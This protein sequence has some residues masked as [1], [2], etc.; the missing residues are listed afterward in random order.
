MTTR[1]HRTY[2]KLRQCLEVFNKGEE[3][4][5]ATE[6]AIMAGLIATVIEGAVTTFGQAV[7]SLFEM[8]PPDLT[9]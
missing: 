2:A 9:P 8:F 3:A 7:V 6:Y 4:P 1:I 5:V